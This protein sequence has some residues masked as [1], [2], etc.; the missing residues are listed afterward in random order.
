MTPI[1]GPTTALRSICPVGRIDNAFLPD[2]SAMTLYQNIS[3][4]VVVLA[5]IISLAALK[6]CP[7]TRSSQ[8]LAVLRMSN[9]ISRSSLCI[10]FSIKAATSSSADGLTPLSALVG[11]PWFFLLPPCCRGL[12][13]RLILAGVFPSGLL[14]LLEDAMGLFEG[15]EG[16]WKDASRLISPVCS[17]YATSTDPKMNCGCNT[18]IGFN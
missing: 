1:C 17:S 3:N 15:V 4:C 6:P 2:K 12:A 7:R 11:S 5:S 18:M 13:D 16:P 10:S 9:R 8:L 14:G